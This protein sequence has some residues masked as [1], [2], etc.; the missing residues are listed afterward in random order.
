MNASQARSIRQM[1]YTVA[2]A[3]ALVAAASP[4]EAAT[5][6]GIVT[7]A[8]GKPVADAVVF[9]DQ[10]NAS[11]VS[12]QPSATMDQIDKTFVPGVLPVVAGTRV[13]FP[14]HDQIHHHVYSF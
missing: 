3:C 9:I 8:G 1:A 12:A 11:P 6:S 13:R 2:C 7:G 4:T 10:P 5:I 14:N